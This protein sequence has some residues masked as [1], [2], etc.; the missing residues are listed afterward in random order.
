MFAIQL[1]GTKKLTVPNNGDSSALGL[2]SLPAGYHI[3]TN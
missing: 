2:P 3:T 1:S